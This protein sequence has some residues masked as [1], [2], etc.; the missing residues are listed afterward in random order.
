MHPLV[1]ARSQHKR[2]FLGVDVHLFVYDG[3]QHARQLTYEQT[4]LSCGNKNA[5]PTMVRTVLT[6]A[7]TRGG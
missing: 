2:F 6:R 5:L 4:L 1:L 3:L 7:L